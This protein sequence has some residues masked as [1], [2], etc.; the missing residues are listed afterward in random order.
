MANSRLYRHLDAS[1]GKLASKIWRWNRP[2]AQA[3]LKMM[4]ASRV[5][6]LV[7]WDVQDRGSSRLPADDVGRPDVHPHAVRRHRS[8]GQHMDR[9][10]QG[11]GEGDLA[12]FVDYLPSLGFLI[13]WGFV[14]HWTIRILRGASRWIEEGLIVIPGFHADWAE[15]TYRI[16]AF[17]TVRSRVVV[18]FPTCLVEKNA[19]VQG[20]SIFIGVLI[21]VGIR[22]AMGMSFPEFC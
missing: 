8:P 15:P 22:S 12:A 11:S 16:L 4:F 19:R 7:N 14:I 13:V 17:L 2:A 3:G 1:I 5:H 9:L 18:A 20:V 10:D 21:S 6:T